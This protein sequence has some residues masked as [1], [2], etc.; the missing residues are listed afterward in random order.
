MGGTEDGEQFARW[1]QYGA[2]SPILRLHSTKNPFHDRRPWGYDAD[3]FKVTRD[4]MQLR[5]A[6]I[7]YLY[8]MAWR[9]H[10]QSVPPILP[11]YYDFPE[12]KAAYACPDQYMYGDK[13]LV[14][15]YIAPKEEQTQLSR[16]AVWLPKGGWYGFYDGVYYPEGWYAYYGKLNE[17]PV[18]ARA[19]AIVPLGKKTGW[20]GINNPDE[21]D[22]Y[23]FPGADG[24]FELYED[25]GDSNYYLNG[26]H[27]T[28]RFK[29]TW[30]DKKLVLQ[31][32]PAEGDVSQ[33]PSRRGYDL[34]FRGIN[35]PKSVVVAVNGKKIEAARKYDPE[36]HTLT[37][38]TV[39][40][41]PAD[42]VEVILTGA[43]DG[44]DY[45]DDPRKHLLQKLI[46]DMRMGT[47]AKTEML[48]ALDELIQ[49]PEGLAR[50]RVEI[51]E[52]HL[53]ALLETCLGAG[54]ER[55]ANHGGDLI[56]VWNNKASDK[57]KRTLNAYI[58]GRWIHWF[59]LTVE[60]GKA[61]TTEVYQPG[62]DF[63]NERPWDLRLDL[64]GILT[65]TEAGGNKA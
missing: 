49:K 6:L 63:A 2:F 34:H 38:D 65:E 37:L 4:A 59:N 27:A 32:L 39:T 7:P 19:G 10:T 3:V 17:I 20:G 9:F 16:K 54:M 46:M 56:V 5:H 45:K 50:Y 62:K 13:L 30:N 24:A 64:A 51:G 23:V 36:T 47:R 22:V 44:L 29:Q 33:V 55:F 42:A 21:L 15:P 18:F 48:G 52:Q 61:E 28:T 25:D 12:E 26:K 57:V 35:A 43:K 14:A 8:S 40:I 53:R 41:T 1:V 31:I 60:H 11:M 58:P